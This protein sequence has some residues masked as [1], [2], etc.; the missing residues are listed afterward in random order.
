VKKRI[1][2]RGSER[3]RERERASEVCLNKCGNANVGE[4]ARGSGETHGRIKV[5][6]S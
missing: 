3:Q 1:R 2:I 4:M 6:A 5:S